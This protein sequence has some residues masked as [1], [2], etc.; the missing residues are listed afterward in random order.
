LTVARYRLRVWTGPSVVVELGRKFRKAG[1]RVPVVGTEN[2]HV[3]VTA[4]DCY[5][6]EQVARAA[7]R[8]KYKKDVGL[9]VRSCW[10]R[11]GRGR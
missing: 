3:D 2:L 1:L 8:R 6:A 9:D 11:R 4:S 10:V 5:G 7:L